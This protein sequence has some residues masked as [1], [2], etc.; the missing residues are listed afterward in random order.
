[1]LLERFFYQILICKVLHASNKVSAWTTD[2]DN[3]KIH[4]I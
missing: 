4:H 2:K 1:M 3:L